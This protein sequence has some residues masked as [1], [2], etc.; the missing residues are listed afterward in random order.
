MKLQLNSDPSYFPKSL[1]G[2]DRGFGLYSIG[3]SFFQGKNESTQ[4]AS[5]LVQKINSF[6]SKIP[7]VKVRGD[8]KVFLERNAENIKYLKENTLDAFT[9]NLLV[10]LNIDFLPNKILKSIYNAFGDAENNIFLKEIADSLSNNKNYM[11][12][13]NR[14]EQ[15]LGIVQKGSLVVSANVSDP[16]FQTM[17]KKIGLEK[18]F[19]FAFFHETAHH[20]EKFADKEFKNSINK[21]IEVFLEKI[22]NAQKI[23]FKISKEGINTFSYIKYNIVSSFDSLKQEIYADTVA[24]LILRNRDIELGVYNKDKTLNFINDIKEIR[25]ESHQENNKGVDSGLY[26]FTHSTAVA[27]DYFHE[28]IQSKGAN[29]M[30]MEEMDVFAKDV[31]SVALARTIQTLKLSANRSFIPQLNTIACVQFDEE[32]G[33]PFLTPENRSEKFI[34]QMQKIKEIAGIEWTDNLSNKLTQAIK[35]SPDLSPSEV[36]NIGFGK[37]IENYIDPINL[38]DASASISNMMATRTH[39]LSTQKQYKPA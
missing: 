30:S 13:Y 21:D 35:T 26:H 39:F 4:F 18:T 17:I 15:S 37:K 14:D 3:D 25:A 34:E 27:M 2:I 19:D 8:S 10:Q 9:K 11:Y 23:D 5:D 6:I 28:K 20:I 16:F 12:T 31:Q 32:T 38:P 22:A 1:E 7:G 24:I 36:F 29:Q 33:M